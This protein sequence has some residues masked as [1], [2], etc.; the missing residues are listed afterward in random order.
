L[1]IMN[2]SGYIEHVK[3][4]NAFGSL[5]IQLYFSSNFGTIDITNL[6]N[7]IY[8]LEIISEK[9]SLTVKV[10]VNNIR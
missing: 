9:T 5:L 6:T 8:M 3:L 4:Y 1:Y 10:L 7:G 2:K